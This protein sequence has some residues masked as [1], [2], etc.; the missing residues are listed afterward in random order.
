MIEAQRH[1]F[2]DCIFHLADPEAMASPTHG[3]LSKDYAAEVAER[4]DGERAAE[5]VEPGDPWPYEERITGQGRPTSRSR[6]QRASSVPSTTQVVTVDREGNMTTLITTLGGAFG[7]M[8][9]IPGTGIVLN[10]GMVSFD[11]E[12]GHANSIRGGR[13]A[14]N[15]A[16]P[17]LMFSEDQPFLTVS[18]SGGRRTVSAIA[19][20]LCNVVDFGMGIQDAIA[21]PRVHCELRQPFIDSRLSREVQDALRDIGH[22]IVVCEETF[23]SPHFGRPVGIL[24]DPTTGRLHGGAAPLLRAMAAGF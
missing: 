11:P 6:S 20:I 12:P 21:A 8:V 17:T 5:K 10:D 16:P 15:F 7:S 9:T 3:L 18:A 14:A 24:R 13:R 4:I 1:A 19:H 22:E 2:T 23:F